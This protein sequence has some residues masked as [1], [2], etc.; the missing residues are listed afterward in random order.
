MFAK[1]LYLSIFVV[2]TL[3]HLVY[4]LP[5][6]MVKNT[7][8]NI[9]RLANLGPHDLAEELSGQF[10]GDIILTDEQASLIE[11][12]ST[13]R[14]GLVQERFRWKNNIVYYLIEESHFDQAQKEFIRE[15]L[16]TLE[17]AT[18][19]KFIPY[20]ATVHGP[21]YIHVIGNESGCFSSV[22]RV[23]GRQRLNLQNSYQPAEGCLRIGTIM[24]EF[25]HAVGFYHMQSATLRD[26][27]VE[28]IWD[29]IEEDKKGNFNKH[30]FD[31]VTSF[32]IEY[33]YDSVMHYGKYG[34]AI[35]SSKETIKPLDPNAE[36]GQ[37]L[38]L[39]PKDIQKLNRMY[40]CA[41][42]PAF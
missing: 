11:G 37:R 27:Y 15:G 34:F 24:H 36:V 29:N 41:E 1:N 3:C 7:P 12:G 19:L 14:Q 30:D 23:G 4:G 33:D 13:I 8:E 40:R 6:N 35:D 38:E 32:G 17:G 20:E 16:D 39:S 21:D 26:R 22:G 42:H 5:R 25:I 10:E 9:E 28:I 31:W 18:C 2:V